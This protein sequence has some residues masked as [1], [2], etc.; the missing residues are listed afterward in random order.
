MPCWQTNPHAT[1][2]CGKGAREQGS[3]VAYSPA[4]WHH[5][6]CETRPSPDPG[7]RKR[8]H[9]CP[10]RRLRSGRCAIPAPDSRRCAKSRILREDTCHATLKSQH[11]FKPQPPTRRV[12]SQAPPSSP[13]S[14]R[15][16]D[17]HVM[18]D[19]NTKKI[20]KKCFASSVRVWGSVTKIGP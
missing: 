15:H 14:S 18:H 1:M 6:P 3:N 8:S 5:S 4:P 12:H 17:T 13:L 20:Q 16:Q 2:Q 7:K 11:V 10:V 9:H 19:Q